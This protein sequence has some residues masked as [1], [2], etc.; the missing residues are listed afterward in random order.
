MRVTDK[1]IAR[2]VRRAKTNIRQANAGFGEVTFIGW[3][4]RVSLKQTLVGPATFAQLVVKY[5]DGD[6]RNQV[7]TVAL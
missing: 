5:I 3:E 1:E 2:E 7:Y 6:H 4:L